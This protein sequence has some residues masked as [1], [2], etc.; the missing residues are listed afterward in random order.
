MPE[1][2]L[3]PERWLELVVGAERILRVPDA[4]VAVRLPRD[5]RDFFRQRVRIEMGKVQIHD[6]YPGLVARGARQP[7]A[8]AALTHLDGT[9]L[10]RLAVYLALRETA[11]VVARHPYRPAA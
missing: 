5:L 3:E 2:L 6:E 1:D 9:A 11:H 4:T 7:G 10:A 8:R